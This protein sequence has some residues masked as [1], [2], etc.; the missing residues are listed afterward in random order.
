MK[1]RFIAGSSSKTNFDIQKEGDNCLF[2]G[3]PLTATTEMSK[4]LSGILKT[5]LFRIKTIEKEEERKTGIQ[6]YFIVDNVDEVVKYIKANYTC[7]S[8]RNVKSF[9]FSD[10]YTNLPHKE[11]LE[12]ISTILNQYMSNDETLTRNELNTPGNGFAF[13]NNEDAKDR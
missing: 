12:E 1:F 5:L 4:E 2:R 10:M 11:I 8:Y 6:K 3:K 9:D 13:S 7:L